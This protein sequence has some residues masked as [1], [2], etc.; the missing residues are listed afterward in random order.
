MES[1]SPVVPGNEQ[2][3][4]VYAA[5]Q[6]EYQPLPVLRTEKSLLMCWRLTDEERAHIASG[7]DLFL[8]VLHFGQPL[9]PLLP[10]AD[11]AEMAMA[12]MIEVEGA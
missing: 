3:E 10:I 2:F 1:I 4:V 11:T 9:Q 7:G 12:I 5:D 6:P 8:C